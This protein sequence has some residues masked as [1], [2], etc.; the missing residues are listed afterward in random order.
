M[1]WTVREIY[2]AYLGWFDGNP[3]HL[4]PLPPKT[5]AYK[6]MRLMGG[7]KKVYEAAKNAFQQE[8]YQWCLELC[9]SLIH[10]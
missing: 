5:H 8:D 10:I 7:Q 1:E 2:A 3:T 9:L 4:H 6:T